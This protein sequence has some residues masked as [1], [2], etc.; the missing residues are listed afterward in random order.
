MVR[1][2]KVGKTVTDVGWT[3]FPNALLIRQRELKLTAHD[4]NNMLHLLRCWWIAVDLPRPS[5][6]TIAAAMGVHPRTV[7]RRIVIM[8]RAGLISRQPRKGPS[9][10]SKTNAYDL[11]PLVTRLTPLA[12]EILKER[13]AKA[14]KRPTLRRPARKARMRIKR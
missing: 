5:K 10:A 9:R 6:A 4:I 1:L 14:E 2:G 13:R 7:Q 11:A 8:E 12:E 3:A